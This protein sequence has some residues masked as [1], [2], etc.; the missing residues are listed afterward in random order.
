MKKILVILVV[1]FLPC[2]C[3]AT[4]SGMRAYRSGNQTIS[5]S[6]STT[7]QLNAVSFDLLGEFST[8]TYRFTAQQSGYY[9]IFTQVYWS[10]SVDQKRHLFDILKIVGG[11]GTIVAL[12]VITTSGTTYLSQTI[13]DIVYLGVGDALQ[14][15]VWQNTGG[16]VNIAGISTGTFISIWKL[17]EVGGGG[18]PAWGDITGTLSNQTDL[19]TALDNLNMDKYYQLIQNASTGAEFYVEKTISYGQALIVFFF[20]L[21]TISFICLIIWRFFWKR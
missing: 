1:L 8:S 11:S 3:S 18:L 2:F 9:S 13:S 19:Q 16:N 7:V 4:Q 17:D 20:T 21:F 10:S 12:A 15:E 14:L 5:S 6:I